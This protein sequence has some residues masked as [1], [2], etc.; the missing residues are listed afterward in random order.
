LKDGYYAQTLTDEIKTPNIFVDQLIRIE[1]VT[2]EVIDAMKTGTNDKEKVEKR[3]EK[4]KLLENKFNEQTGM[5]C[6]VVE[7][8]NGGKYS[9]YIYKRYN[10]VR[11]VMARISKLH[12]QAGIGII[13][14][15]RVTNLILCSSVR[16]KTINRQKLIIILNSVNKAQKKVNRFLL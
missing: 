2:S 5:T 13:L 7:L 10:D 6:R 1:D 16:T 4:I 11:L 14:L 15:I 12:Q 9:M 3:D 8:Y